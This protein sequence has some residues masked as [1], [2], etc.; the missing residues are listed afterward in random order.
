M[1][2][3]RRRTD[4]MRA[5]PY[6]ILLSLLC[7]SAAT[8]EIIK[9]GSLQANS[10]GVNVTLHWMTEDESNVLRFEVERRYG[11]ESDFLKIGTLDAKGASLYEF[12]DYS[13][14][15][16]TTAVYQYRV[17]VVFSN[18]TNPLYSQLI[19]VSHTVSGIRKTWGSIKAMFR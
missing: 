2:L 10:D 3:K 12:V 16:K 17:K 6:I 11:T 7:I 5:I 15:Q 19:T 4:T 14:F 18:G 9:S 1:Y 8:A 13:A